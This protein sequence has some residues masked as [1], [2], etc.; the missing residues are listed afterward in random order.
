[1]KL[2]PSQVSAKVVMTSSAKIEELGTAQKT[3]FEKVRIL[4]AEISFLLLN[5]G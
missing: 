5:D 1:M 4:S 2:D 3:V